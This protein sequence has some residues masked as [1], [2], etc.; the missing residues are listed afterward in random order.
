MRRLRARRGSALILVL[1]MT[2]AVAA[3]AIAAIFM[4]SSAGLLSRFYDRERLFRYAAESALEITR[5]RM[6]S[7]GG[8][9]V[10]DTGVRVMASGWQPRTAA[11]TLIGGVSVNVYAAATGDTT[12]GQLPFVTLLAQAYDAN[13]T[14]HVRRMDFRRESFSRYQFFVDSFPSGVTFGPGIVGGRV[15]SNGN[16]VNSSSGNRFL[17]TVSVSGTVSGTATFEID[18]LPGTYPIDWPRDSTYPRLDTLANAAGLRFIPATGLG[19]GSRL[20]FVAIDADNDGTIESNEGFFKVFTLAAGFDTTRLRGNPVQYS[21]LWV[22]AIYYSWDDDIIQN[23]CGAFYRISNRW[24]FFPIAVHRS[25]WV[26][27]LLVDSASFPNISNGTMNGFDDYDYDAVQDILEQPT[28]RCF[29]AGSPYL[30]LTERYTNSAGTHTGTAADTVPFG[31]LAFAG[32]SGRGGQDTTFTRFVR[33]CRFSTGTTGR[34]QTATNAALGYWESGTNP[35][36]VSAA[37]RQASE[38]QYLFA[39]SPPYNAASRG[40]V[41]A[42]TGPLYLSGTVVGNVTLRVNGRVSIVDELVYATPPNTPE[43]DCSTQLG[44]VA[45]GD[46]TV[47]N[48]MFTRARRYGRYVSFFSLSSFTQHLGGVTSTRVHGALMSLTGT[49]GVEEPNTTMGASGEQPECPEGAGSSFRAN[50]GC[51]THVGSAAMKRFSSHYSG[52]NNGF[53]YFGSPDRCSAGTKRP[54]FFPLTNRYRLVRTLE[55][56]QNQAN[57][58][59]KIRTLLLRLKGKAL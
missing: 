17:D 57:T 40:V 55:I 48:G 20:E 2:L 39:L 10:P 49:V 41:S 23:Q 35:T 36:G 16:W 32:G 34:C 5:S 8:P 31:T 59:A 43:S 29:P 25:P 30:M 6:E 58:P 47:V 26:R 1:L 51:F 52:S 28:G 50:G 22:G 54:P 3:L 4:S 46:V 21:H 45:V 12:G 24:Q 7:E 42:T 56:A 11:G 37:V 38:L 33:T 19:R 53:R 44:V 18:S 15:H 9:A 14:R 27:P 13:G